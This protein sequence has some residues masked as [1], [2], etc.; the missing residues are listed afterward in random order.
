MVKPSAYRD[1]F[2]GALELM[3][4]QTLRRRPMHGYAH[5]TGHQGW[6]E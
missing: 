6:I 1:L 3:I 2:P 4:L 5:R